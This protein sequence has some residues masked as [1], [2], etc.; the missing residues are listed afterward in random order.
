[1]K[2][3]YSLELL[4]FCAAACIFFGHYVHFYMHYSIPENSGLFFKINPSNIGGLAVP[5][6]FMMSGA[7]FTRNYQ[8]KISNKLISAKDF[9]A[10][11]IARLYPLHFITLIL[12]ALLQF[13]IFEL[14]SK[15]F[16]YDI[17]DLKHFFLNVFFI[18]HWGFESGNSFNAPVWSVSHE[19]FLYLIFF[20]LCVFSRYINFSLLSIGL[21]IF[22]IPFLSKVFHSPLLKSAFAFFVGVVIYKVISLI[23]AHFGSRLI[24]LGL[25]VSAISFFAFTGH[26]FESRGLPLG[27][28]GPIILVLGLAIDLGLPE[29]MLSKKLNWI[30]FLGGISYST[31]LWH[32]PIQLSLV[33]FSLLIV[34]LDFSS[35]T[36]LFTYVALVLLISILSFL[37]VERPM[38]RHILKKTNKITIN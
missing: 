26:Y 9:V 34:E 4:R 16:I 19:I 5:I 3:L 18:S 2:K 32:F 27:P 35:S 22:G 21:V 17:N 13:F 20:I 31:Y 12:V 25:V 15:F 7:I 24:K 8:Y 23:F 28:V 36:I 33:L 10:R 29:N 30:E 38:Q 1:M 11:R 6:F 14:I 37:F